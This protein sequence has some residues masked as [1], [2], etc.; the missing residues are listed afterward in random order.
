M[1]VGG[2][3]YVL[4]KSD[5]HYFR[6]QMT[7]H[8][9]ETECVCI[10]CLDCNVSMYVHIMEIVRAMLG[11]LHLSSHTSTISKISVPP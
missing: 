3:K 6:Q 4:V 10:H 7:P 11:L 8:F 9:L 5:S 2:D 1:M